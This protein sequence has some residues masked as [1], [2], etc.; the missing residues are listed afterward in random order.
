MTIFSSSRYAGGVKGQM[1]DRHSTTYTSYV[2]RAQQVTRPIAYFEYVVKER[3]RLDMLAYIMLG[4]EN[5][6]WEIMD[7]NPEVHDPLH[8]TPGMVLRIPSE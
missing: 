6:W 7:Y 5:R 2:F 1:A 3:D 4:D 8:L